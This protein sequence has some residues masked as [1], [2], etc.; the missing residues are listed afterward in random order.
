[1]IVLI[2]PKSCKPPEQVETKA[3]ASQK[4]QRLHER[5]LAKKRLKA[6]QAKLNDRDAL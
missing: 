4:V 1:M 6:S 5:G 2:T 3:P